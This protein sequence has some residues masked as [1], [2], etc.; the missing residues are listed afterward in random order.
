M[1]FDTTL[2]TTLIVIK[3]SDVEMESKRKKKTPISISIKYQVI[4]Q[5]EDEKKKP[6]SQRLTLEEIAKKFNLSSKQSV[7]VIYS[8]KEK[9]EKQYHMLGK[10]ASKKSC[11]V[12]KSH[13]PKVEEALAIW[14]RSMRDNGIPLSTSLVSEKAREIGVKMKVENFKGS[15]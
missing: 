7:S 10:K 1:K 9:Y 15:D 3:I 14:L 4:Q 2:I 6:K 13:Y 8:K 11:N 12:G 5:V